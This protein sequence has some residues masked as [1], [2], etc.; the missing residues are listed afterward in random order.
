[1]KPA[2]FDY[3]RIDSSDEIAAL[4]DQYGSDGRILAGGQSLMAMLNIRLAQPKVLL[5]ISRCKDL[6][7]ARITDGHLCVGAAATQ[8]SV[9]WRPSLATELPLLHQVFPW[10][11]HFQVR[12]RGTVCGSVAHAD[13]SAELPL[14]LV[15]LQ[16]SVVLR[17]A[18]GRRVLAADQFFRGMLSTAVEPGEFVEEVRFPLHK[19]GQRHAFREVSMR[20]GDFALVALAA[21]IT[22]GAL[23]LTAGGVAD[24][25]RRVRWEKLAASELDDA[26]NDFSWSLEAESDTHAS[27]SYRRHLVRSI[28]RQLL[29]ETAP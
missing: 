11:S 13:P 23:E 7:Y 14:C 20:H 6:D 26:L 10:I 5:D 27:A 24:R 22:D 9:E 4:L 18:R 29:T 15:A 8:A 16:G 28:G 12:N 19:A 2:A 25:P 3:I 21:T 1:M 17:S